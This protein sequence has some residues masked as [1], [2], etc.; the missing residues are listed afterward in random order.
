MSLSATDLLKRLAEAGYFQSTNSDAE[1]FR[2]TVVDQLHTEPQQALEALL[3]AGYVDLDHGATDD[4]VNYLDRWRLTLTQR[5]LTAL[6][7]V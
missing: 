5:G 6:L 1:L 4:P 2:R 7:D 3:N